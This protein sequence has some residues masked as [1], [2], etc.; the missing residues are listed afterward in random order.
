MENNNQPSPEVLQPQTDESPATSPATP[1]GGKP[2]KGPK[3]L[4]RGSYRPSHKATFIGA[5]VVM[6]ILAI[7]V[8]II[9]FFMRETNGGEELNRSEVTLS[10]ETL[11]KLGVSKN[12]V[13]TRGAELV[14]GPNARFNGKVTI[15]SDITIAGKLNL[16]NTFVAQEASLAKLQAGDVTL[17]QLGVNGDATVTNANVR[18]TLSVAGV[19][20][21]Q[22]PVTLSQLLTVNNSI[23]VAGNLA[24]GGVLSA[25]TFQASS[26]VSDT[27][28]TIGGHVISR[29]APP[30][31]S[32]GGALGSGGTA[33]ISGSDTAGTVAANVGVGA[34]PGIVASVSFRQA[35]SSTPRVIVTA[36]GSGPRNVYVSRSATGFSI[37]VGDAMP[38]GGWAF[39]YFVIQ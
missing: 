27:T 4:K 33:S 7:N 24:I 29:G 25:R 15:G 30:S 26:L 32:P 9:A 19:T 13:G 18:Q 14:V 23:N 6:F 21:L 12:P 1:P 2:G 22:G 38:P 11:D 3:Q 17:Q 8:G 31:L 35:Y 34:S 28:L 5:A 36:V 39:D 37:G 20:R 10:S 16:N